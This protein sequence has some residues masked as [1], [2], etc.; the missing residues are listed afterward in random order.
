[1]KRLVLFVALA[2]CVGCAKTKLDNTLPVQ[3]TLAGGT[4]SIRLFNFYGLNVDVTVNNLPLTSYA[5]GTQAG[6]VEQNQ[7]G[8]SLFPTGAWADGV[9]FSIP[10]ALLDKQGNAR[11]RITPRGISSLANVTYAT[12]QSVDTVLHNDALNP[13]DYYVLYTGQLLPV[14]HDPAA[15]SQ[16]Q[17]FK[18]RVINLTTVPDTFGFAGPVS[19]TYA[20]GASVDPALTK[21]PP[22]GI[23]SYIELPLGAYQFKLFWNGDPSKQLTE[24]P[25]IPNFNGDGGAQSPQEAI[26]PLIRTFKAGATYSIVVTR[27][28]QFVPSYPPS[29][30]LPPVLI[31]TNSYHIITEQS[32]AYNST[33]ACMDAAS[34]LDL[35]GISIAVDGQPLGTHLGFGQ[36]ASHQVY[37][38]GNHQV[39]IL[40][41]QGQVI[42]QE[43]IM[44]YPNDYLTAWAYLNPQGKPDLVFS[45]TDMTSTLYQTNASGQVVQNNGSY[46]IPLLDDGTNG[47][48]RIQG[49][50]YMWQIRFL[51]LSED[52]PYATL[53]SDQVT[54]PGNDEQDVLFTYLNAYYGYGVDSVNFATATINLGQGE[55]DAYDPFLMFPVNSNSFWQ[56]AD[57]SSAAATVAGYFAFQGKNLRVYQS[58]VGPPAIVPGVMLT[59]VGPL[60]F[61]QFVAN[62]A[63]YTSPALTPLVE[64]GY[65]TVALVGRAQG[66]D[67]RLIYVKHNQ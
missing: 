26:L 49:N 55:T 58:Q 34:A 62:P 37:V 27:N 2:L 45:S 48:L 23:G 43:S 24:P 36:S 41:Q 63:M 40:N 12:A 50:S 32:P 20:N 7:V 60:P 56:Q 31:P 42:G 67:G 35:P 25:L 15:P 30:Q 38:A 8:L 47:S 17:L 52:V 4:S 59:G 28:F 39:Q 10:N 44:M 11:V 18:I 65:Y 3:P 66:T 14:P 9:A 54:G 33:Y 51:N 22:G 21:V 6:G 64:S 1:M 53:G 5:T 57:G 16:P 29:A 19:V 13:V 61:H 46:T